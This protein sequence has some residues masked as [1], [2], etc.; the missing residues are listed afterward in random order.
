MFNNLVKDQW[1]IL[2]RTRMMQ[3]EVID[4]WLI[5]MEFEKKF[6]KVSTN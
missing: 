2:K 3:H 4:L 1:Q 6:N 5:T